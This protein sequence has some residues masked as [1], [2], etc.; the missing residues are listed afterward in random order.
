LLAAAANLPISYMTAIEGHAHSRFG[1]GGMLMTDAVS[2]LIVG[3]TV[4]FALRHTKL[5]RAPIAEPVRN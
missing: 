3:T 4:L 2:T 1:L 5:G